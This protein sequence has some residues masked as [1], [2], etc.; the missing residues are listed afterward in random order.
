MDYL[1]KYLSKEDMEYLLK[2]MDGNDV[3]YLVMHEDK[4]CEIIE[5]LLSI[6]VKNIKEIIE[7]KV[8]I[9]YEAIETI[10]EVI[11]ENGMEET[12]S[13]INDDIIN[14]NLFD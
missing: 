11:K 2:K 12:V 1:N 14:F 10:K 8:E 4:I 3:N 5:Y 9:F 6:G 7:Y 13:L